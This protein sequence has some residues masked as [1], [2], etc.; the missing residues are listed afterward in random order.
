MAEKYKINNLIFTS[1]FPIYEKNYNK[2]IKENEPPS[3]K[4]FTVSLNIK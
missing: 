2:P 1:T 4:I 3:A